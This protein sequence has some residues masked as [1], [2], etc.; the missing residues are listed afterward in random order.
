MKKIL[1]EA[2]QVKNKKFK[3]L[4]EARV[5]IDQGEFFSEC[6]GG[7]ADVVVD[8]TVG[9]VTQ[10]LLSPATSLEI[11]AAIEECQLMVGISKNQLAWFLL[12]NSGYGGW[13][14]AYVIDNSRIKD[15]E[16]HSFVGKGG[17][18]LVRR[19]VTFAWD[20]SGWFMNA[21]PID[22][23]HRWSGS[24]GRVLSRNS[25]ASQS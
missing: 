10:P 6:F 5:G 17:V 23:T 4:A 9:L 13:F 16:R 20:S 19:P 3:T 21:S 15:D 11:V 22:S 2:V 25:A 12:N 8:S 14:I 7:I 18:R 1:G 24:G